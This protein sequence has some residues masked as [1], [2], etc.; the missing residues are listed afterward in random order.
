MTDYRE[1]L[2]KYMLLVIDREGVTFAEFIQSTVEHSEKWL[3][4]LDRE[5]LA[6]LRDEAW[7]RWK[8]MRV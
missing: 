8:D 6:Q 3:T 2:I 7:Q 4:I 5:A 1:L